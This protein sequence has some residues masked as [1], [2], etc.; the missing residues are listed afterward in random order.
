MDIRLVMGASNPKIS[1]ATLQAEVGAT[2]TVKGDFG[3]A[4]VTIENNV[5]NGFSIKLDGQY[6]GIIRIVGYR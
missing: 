5:I 3:D 4:T 2:A 6:A 1:R